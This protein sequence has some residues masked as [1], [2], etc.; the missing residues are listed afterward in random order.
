[1]SEQNMRFLIDIKR[2]LALFC[3]VKKEDVIQSLD[4]ETI[5]DVPNLM[6]DEGLDSVVLKKLDLSTEKQPALTEWNCL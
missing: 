6:F 3:N 2:K 5:Y 1:M 4:A